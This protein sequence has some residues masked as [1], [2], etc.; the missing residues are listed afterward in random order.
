MFAENNHS[1]LPEEFIY[2][3]ITV[4][5]VKKM[6]I[7][8]PNKKEK[9]NVKKELTAFQNILS[10]HRDSGKDFECLVDDLCDFRPETLGGYTTLIQLTS[11]ILLIK[12]PA[13][14]LSLKIAQ[15]RSHVC[16]IPTTNS[17]EWHENPVYIH[18]MAKA[19]LQS[20][21]TRDPLNLYHICRELWCINDFLFYVS[22]SLAWEAFYIHTEST[23]RE[24]LHRPRDLDHLLG[25]L[26]KL[27]VEEFKEDLLKLFV[28]L[29][30]V[31][32]IFHMTLKR[33]ASR[34]IPFCFTHQLEYTPQLTEKL[35]EWFQSTQQILR[36]NSC[37]NPE[38]M[39][40]REL[41]EYEIVSILSHHSLP[42]EEMM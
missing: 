17:D 30:I 29:K 15:L 35:L 27:T 22:L 13:I 20:L 3:G 9:Q 5:D 2:S 6:Q 41:L 38:Q 26:E 1:K 18:A 25:Q 24:T 10:G 14:S 7:L 33:T 39:R 34:K 42:G 21:D 16:N 12:N 32:L 36:I 19:I 40:I 4:E 23:D 11:G 8:K 31:A 37:E 28:C